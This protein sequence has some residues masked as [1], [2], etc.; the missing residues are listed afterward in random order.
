M[1]DNKR[2]GALITFALLLIAVTCGAAENADGV[3]V[4]VAHASQPT[5]FNFTS[6]LFTE[7]VAVEG[8]QSDELYFRAREWF[9]KAFKSSNKVLQMDSKERMTLVGKGSIEVP[10][11]SSF[12]P[13]KDAAGFVHFTL[14]IYLKD[15]RYKYE[16]TDARHE[17]SSRGVTSA[18]SLY[19]SNADGTS[20]WF[21]KLTDGA[22]EYIK[23]Y[24]AQRLAGLVDSL[25]HD[26]AQ[27]VAAT[28]NN[29]W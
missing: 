25:K 20:V 28:K 19:K 26:M 16:I 3:K 23:E 17:T 29:D 24:S 18:G 6:P 21:G 11:G 22:F 8:A 13:K 7:V 10:P 1:R 5:Q 4:A 27:K 2:L 9:S 15:G 12:G 14:A